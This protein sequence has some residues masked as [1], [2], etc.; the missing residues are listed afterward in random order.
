MLTVASTQVT[1]RCAI[2]VLR[3][4]MTSSRGQHHNSLSEE[5]TIPFGKPNFPFIE[6]N[7]VLGGAQN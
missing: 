4:R 6:P 2:A 3:S 5:V 1:S 7:L